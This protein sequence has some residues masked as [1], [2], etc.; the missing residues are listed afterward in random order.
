MEDIKLAKLLIVDD[1]EYNISLLERI[2]AR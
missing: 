2:L 1:Q